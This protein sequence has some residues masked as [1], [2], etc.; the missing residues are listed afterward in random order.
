[1]SL[2]F[3]PSPVSILFLPY[4]IHHGTAPRS[5]L[6]S[7]PPLRS[8]I[9][10]MPTFNLLPIFDALAKCHMATRRTT[11]STIHLVLLSLPSILGLQYAMTAPFSECRHRRPTR[12]R[13]ALR[14]VLTTKMDWK[15]IRQIADGAA[16]FQRR[17]Q[18]LSKSGLQN[19]RNRLIPRMKRRM[20]WL[21]PPAYRQPKSPTG[22]SMRGA[23]I[24]ERR[25]GSRQ[26]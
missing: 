5:Q 14:T 26:G 19:T 16:I 10:K 17:Q 21:F 20:H 23:G 18:P 11:T 4:S 9:L 6:P 1:M 25:P 3:L 13:R 7:L 12:I 22:S 8:T 15:V 2:A 24:L